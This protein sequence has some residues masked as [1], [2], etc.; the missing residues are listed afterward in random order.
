MKEKSNRFMEMI[1]NAEVLLL[2]LHPL[3]HFYVSV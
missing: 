2:I 1:P 3:G